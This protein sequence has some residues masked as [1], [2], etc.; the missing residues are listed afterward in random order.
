MAEVRNHD[1]RISG[2]LKAGNIEMGQVEITPV[3][4][5]PTSTTVSGLSLAGTGDVIGLCTTQTSVP[6]S[7]VHESSVSSVAA[8]GMTVWIYRTNTTA[9]KIGWLMFRKR[10]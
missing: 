2:R 1:L 9:T 3:A 10:A 5:T 8:T 6:G 7:E 4:N